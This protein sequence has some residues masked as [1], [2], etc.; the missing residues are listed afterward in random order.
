MKVKI[1]AMKGTIITS[2]DPIPE[3]TYGIKIS[4]RM[5]DSITNGKIAVEGPSIIDSIK[6]IKIEIQNPNLLLIIVLQ[7]YCFLYFTQDFIF[8]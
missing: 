5:S 3:G 6:D 1:D 7:M 8:L 4:S 2:R